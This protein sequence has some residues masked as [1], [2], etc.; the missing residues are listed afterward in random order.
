MFKSLI[1]AAAIA[2]SSVAHAAQSSSPLLFSGQLQIMKDFVNV[3]NAL[4][5][6]V[7]DENNYKLKMG[8]IPGTMKMFVREIN[9]DEAWLQQD[10]NL[11]IQQQ[12]VEALIDLNTGET[13]R[14]LV[15]GQ[16]QD[17]PKADF[18]IIDQKAA[19]VTV[20]AGTFDTMY[21]KIKDNSSGQTSEQWVNPRVIAVSGMAKSVAQSQIGQVTI[22]LTST[23]KN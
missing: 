23:K 8:F 13:K 9:G 16:D 22:E 15:N 12:K 18:E 10:I 1:V 20:P 19:Q 6:N 5:W 7:G 21:I 14:I 3:Q 11:A 2:L 4:G 17:V